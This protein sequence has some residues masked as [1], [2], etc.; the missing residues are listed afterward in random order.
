M[1]LALCIIS[2]NSGTKFS[3]RGLFGTA[4]SVGVAAVAMPNVAR[5]QTLRWRMVTSWPKN[6]TGPALSARRIAERIT[7][8]SGGRLQVDVFAAGEIVPAFATF[9]AVANNTVEMAHTAALYWQ[10]VFPAAGLFT[11]APFGLSPVEHQAWIEF[12]GGQALWDELY[13]PRG[14]RGFLA[15]NTGP[16]MGGW[17]RKPIQAASDIKGLR[18]RVQGLGAQIYE[19]LGAT[20]M[21]IAAGEI[22]PAIEKGVI[23]GVEFLGPANDFDTGIARYAPYYYMPGFNKPNGASECLVNRARF[24]ALPPDLQAI[25][26]EA[27]RAEHGQGLAESFQTNASALISLLQTY[28]IKIERFPDSLLIEAFSATRSLM[29]DIAERDPLSKRIVSHYGEAQ[30]SLRGWSWLSADMGRI[31][32]NITR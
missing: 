19:R 16:S 4:L 9:D 1:G 25:I 20:P 28:P 12:M 27:C 23:D 10:S 6:R 29:V 21:A 11:T 14:V 24:E 7:L 13:A 26:A 17:F 3:R 30:K 2:M 5:S 8:M 15:G 22:L 31:L 32:A 18:I